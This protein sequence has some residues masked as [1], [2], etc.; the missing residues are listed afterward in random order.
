MD[1]C[2][3]RVSNEDSWVIDDGVID[4][5]REVLLEFL[6]GV[7]NVLRKLNG[8]GARQLENRDGHGGLVVEQSAKRVAGGPKFQAGDVLEQRLFAVLAGLDNDLAKLLFIDQPPLGVDLKFD[9]DGLA[10][11]L[12]PDSAGRD[13]HILLADG[14]DN[15][16]GGQAPGRD[17]VWVEP[18]AH[19]VIARAENLD[20]SGARDSGKHVLDLQRG[21]VAQIDVVVTVI[22]RN[23][24]DDHR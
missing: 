9:G 12:L 2:L 21:V 11:R 14:A 15:I 4:P 3:D 16:A 13:L 1:D 17:L 22:G 24:M 8:V 20:R 19:R 23:E 7:A 10:D 6:H 5:L 18:N